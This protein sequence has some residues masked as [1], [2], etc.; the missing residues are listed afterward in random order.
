MLNENE[1]ESKPPYVAIIFAEFVVIIM[2]AVIVMFMIPNGSNK[3]DAANGTRVVAIEG[4]LIELIKESNKHGAALKTLD[5]WYSLSAADVAKT[6]A[7][8]K[9]KKWIK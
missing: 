6:T 5:A 8:M 1:I 7:Y 3:E 4:R 9:K 2:L